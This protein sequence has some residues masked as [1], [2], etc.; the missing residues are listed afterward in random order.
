MAGPTT[1]NTAPIFEGTIN[2]KGQQFAAADTTTKKT[3]FTAAAQGSRVDSI[4]LA[5][6]DTTAVV[7]NFYVSDG[8]T[9]FYIGLITIVIGAGYTTVVKQ[10]ALP[11]ISPKLGYIALPTGWVLKCACNATMTAAKVTDVVAFGGDF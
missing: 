11:G 2:N 7:M 1:G 5:T 8:V 6:N 4:S 9:D 10:D 3:I